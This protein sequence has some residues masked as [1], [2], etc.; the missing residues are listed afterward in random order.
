MNV[1]SGNE[2]KKSRKKEEIAKS[3][4]V[5]WSFICALNASLISSLSLSLSQ[6]IIVA[7]LLSFIY[8]SIGR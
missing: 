1:S 6:T 3:E 7:L 2:R 8:E 4:L 5:K